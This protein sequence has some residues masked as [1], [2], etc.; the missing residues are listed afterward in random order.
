MSGQRPSGALVPR[1]LVLFKSEHQDAKCLA[2][3]IMN[4]L[5]VK[6]PAAVTDHLDQCAP[7]RT[8]SSALNSKRPGYMHSP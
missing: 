2:I 3:A 8:M 6:M 5:A 1:L 7:P 4:M